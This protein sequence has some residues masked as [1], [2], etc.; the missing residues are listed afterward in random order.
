M[1]ATLHGAT[2]TDCLSLSDGCLALLVRL[3]DAASAHNAPSEPH[4]HKRMQDRKK[5][6][7]SS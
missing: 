5:I 7:G 3:V 1:I 2:L 4:E 6:R